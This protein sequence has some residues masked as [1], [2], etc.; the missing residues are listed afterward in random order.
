[1][2]VQNNFATHTTAITSTAANMAN[3]WLR[4][5]T[6]LRTQQLSSQLQL[7]LLISPCAKITL[8]RKVSFAPILTKYI[9]MNNLMIALLRFYLLIYKTR[10]GI[11]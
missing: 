7:N 2:V 4:K 11:E 5:I 6:L 1:M 9:Q 8:L 10:N 3:L